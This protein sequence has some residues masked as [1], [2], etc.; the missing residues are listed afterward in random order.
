[1]R[2]E[3]ESRLAAGILVAAAL[4]YFGSQWN[5][6]RSNVARDRAT[7]RGIAMVSDSVA[8]EDAD[9]GRLNRDLVTTTSF[10]HRRIST[11]LLLGAI[12][13]ALPAEAAITTLRIDTT[14]VD[15]V[16]LSPRTAA[17]VD[18][19]GRRSCS[20]YTNDHRAGQS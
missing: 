3:A 10:S 8:R 9:L 20:R 12:T 14:T 6:E 4:A 16:T 5:I 2:R 11:A 17:V 18:A 7:I 13:Q 1:M 19:L 15:I